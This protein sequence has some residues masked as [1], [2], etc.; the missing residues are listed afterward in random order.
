MTPL[1]CKNKDIPARRSDTLTILGCGA[2]LAADI[3]AF[4][5]K[6][7]VMAISDATAYYPRRIDHACSRHC[8]ILMDSLVAI[9]RARK[10]NLDF[11]IHAMRS[12]PKSLVVTHYWRPQEKAFSPAG[13]GHFAILLGVSMGYKD[14]RLLGVP[15]DDKGHFYDVL[16]VR[17]QIHPVYLERWG[18]STMRFLKNVR[19]ASG[20]SAELLGVI[21]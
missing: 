3:A 15:M 9:R 12:D 10:Y 21:T 17:G 8:G 2:C 5:V 19:S 6:G 14:I 16:P 13:S 20:P 11:S 7:D 1:I 4:G 18:E